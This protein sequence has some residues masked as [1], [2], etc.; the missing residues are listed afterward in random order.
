MTKDVARR[1]RYKLRQAARAIARRHAKKS[2]GNETVVMTTQELKD[3]EN[4]I[5]KQFTP[6]IEKALQF[7]GRYKIEPDISPWL[8]WGEI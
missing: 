5:I 2:M 8:K 3:R 1:N 4:S 6:F 7:D